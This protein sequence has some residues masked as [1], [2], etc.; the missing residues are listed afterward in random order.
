MRRDR[1][2]GGDY[3]PRYVDQAAGIAPIAGAEPRVGELA[4]PTRQGPPTTWLGQYQPTEAELVRWGGG[5]VLV[6]DPNGLSGLGAEQRLCD[7][8]WPWPVVCFVTLNVV[9]VP[10]PNAAPWATPVVFVV[11][12]GV[13]QAASR[14]QFSLGPGNPFLSGQPIPMRQGAVSV[15]WPGAAANEQ[16]VEVFGSLVPFLG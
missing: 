8:T 9:P 13:G 5:A 4:R 10:T 15:Q 7:A 12:F 16:R 1:Y 14:T 2:R 3:R 6:P 11:N